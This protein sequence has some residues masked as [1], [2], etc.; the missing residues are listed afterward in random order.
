MMNLYGYWSK[1]LS[2]LVKGNFFFWTS[3]YRPFG[4][5]VYRTLFALFGF[6]PRPVYV[7]FYAAMLV[8]LLLAYLVLSRI[9]GSRE[10]GVIATLLFCFHGKLDYLYYNAGSMYDVFCF[11]FYFL[12]LLIYLRARLQDRL[13][14]VWES[15]GFLACFIC[16]LNSKEMAATL[17]VMVLLWEL[18][19]HS[20][21]FR[22]FRALLPLDH[23][24]GK[25]GSRWARSAC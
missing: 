8:N 17:P 25:N 13:L 2:A 5:I 16:A 18:I 14:G 12:A 3:Y 15:L 24:G 19:F 10:I 4:G 6:N 21:D 1:P 7:V 20:P 9:G 11:L 23:P 22:S